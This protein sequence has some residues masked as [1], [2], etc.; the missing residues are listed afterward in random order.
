MEVGSKID[1]PGYREDNTPRCAICERSYIWDNRYMCEKF[2]KRKK[3]MKGVQLLGVEISPVGVCD[4][5]KM[6]I[7]F[8]ESILDEL[9]ADAQAQGGMGYEKGAE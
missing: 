5:F 6:N 4:D 1:I 8:R 2:K 7:L 3:T 9:T